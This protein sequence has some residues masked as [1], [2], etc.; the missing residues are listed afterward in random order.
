MSLMNMMSSKISSFRKLTLYLRTWLSR[1]SISGR[2]SRLE[3]FNNGHN[4]R[5]INS[6]S[7][8]LKDK[9][10][11]S[12]SAYGWC[13]SHYVYSRGQCE[14]N[15]SLFEKNRIDMEKNDLITLVFDCDNRRISIVNQ[16][17]NAKHDMTV[18]TDSCQFPWQLHVIL[19]EPKS[20]VRILAT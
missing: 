9:S 11:M 5:G 17:T 1:E 3:L 10:Y 12:P 14:L 18:D 15:F 2:K 7:M 20:R 8:P 13:S 16:R 6:N 4:D 19:K